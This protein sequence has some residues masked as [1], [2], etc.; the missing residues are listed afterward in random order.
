VLRISRLGIDR[1]K[2]AGRDDAPFV[3]RVQSQDVETDVLARAVIDA[4][5]TYDSPNPLGGNGVPAIGEG[6]REPPRR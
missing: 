1:T 4:S 5:G 6:W 2:N 3:L